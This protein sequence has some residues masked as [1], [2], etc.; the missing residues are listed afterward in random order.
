MFDQTVNAI[1]PSNLLE[2]E[3]SLEEKLSTTGVTQR[4]LGLPLHSNSLGSHQNSKLKSW[5][6]PV[7]SFP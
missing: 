2:L 6:D 3:E 5:T 1:L 4:N 7:S